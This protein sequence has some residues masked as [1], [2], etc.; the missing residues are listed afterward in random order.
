[1]R[2]DNGITIIENDELHGG[3]NDLNEK[4]SEYII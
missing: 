3:E 4:S 2:H 1:V